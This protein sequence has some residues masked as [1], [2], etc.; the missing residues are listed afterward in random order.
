VAVQQSVELGPPG[1]LSGLFLECVCPVLQPEALALAGASQGQSAAPGTERHPESAGLPPPAAQRA[2]WGAGAGARRQSPPSTAWQVVSRR[3]PK[4]RRNATTCSFAWRCRAISDAPMRSPCSGRGAA[5]G[6]RSPD[7]PGGFRP[8]GPE[9]PVSRKGA[10]L[11][12]DGFFPFAEL[13]RQ[14]AAAWDHRADSP[15]GSKRDGEIDAACARPRFWPLIR[16]QGAPPI[17][18]ISG[19]RDA[20][21]L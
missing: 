7:E 19:A 2:R 1:L 11:S 10:L 6:D 14:L 18:C 5:L 20:C 9:R 12:S 17:S 15:G 13:P 8:A 4:Q 16:S 21:Q 3:A